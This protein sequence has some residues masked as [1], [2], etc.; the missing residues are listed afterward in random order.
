[1]RGLK[2]R[3]RAHDVEVLSANEQASL[4]LGGLAISFELMMKDHKSETLREEKDIPVAYSNS[5]MALPCIS[6]VTPLKETRRASPE[7]V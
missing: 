3:V 4:E 7:D 5:L 1:V 6:T 2:D